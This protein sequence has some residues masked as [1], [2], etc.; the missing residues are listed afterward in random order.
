MIALVT[1]G[2][3]FLGKH[4][5]QALIQERFSIRAL[6]R[7]TSYFNSFEEKGVEPCLGD[8]RDRR[9]LERAV[10][11]AQVIFH[12]AALV[13]DWAPLHEFKAI[14]IEGTRNLLEAAS[15][16]GVPKFIHVS[17]NDV[18]GIVGD[19]TIGED[20]LYLPSGF[21]YPDT[22]IAAE[23]LVFRYHNEGKVRAS[24][25]YP[26]WIFGPGDKT[27]VPEIVH[28]LRSKQMILIGGGRSP[29]HLSYVENLSQA[30]ILMSRKEE[31]I[32]EGF[33]LF[34]G[35]R[36]TWR[37]FICRIAD[38]LGVKRPRLSLHPSLAY[39]IAA[40]LEGGYSLFGARKRPVLTRYIVRILSNHLKY[41]GSKIYDVLGFR[42]KFSLESGIER[43]LQWL[44]EAKGEIQ[45]AK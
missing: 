8:L 10:D 1:G 40:S 38:Y 37:D 3:G 44:N 7:K 26:I 19:R 2:T 27:L 32:G 14:N 22:K 11:G 18:F 41:D 28:A 35:E 9:S 30:M 36:L 33:L 21:P 23:K 43:T 45:K 17:T 34:D 12:C 20:H 39:G 13:T 4:L 25:I 5:I 24:V 15:T 31:A 42:P 16:C 29:I 6:V